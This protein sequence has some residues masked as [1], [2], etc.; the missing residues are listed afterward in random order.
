MGSIS[1]ALTLYQIRMILYRLFDPL[2]LNADVPL[3]GAGTAMLQQSLNQ[4][5]IETIGFVD[6]GCMSRLIE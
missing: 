3:R 2:W 5:N 6:L 1:H 4:G